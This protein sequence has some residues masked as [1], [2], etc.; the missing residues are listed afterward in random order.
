MRA[1][2]EQDHRQIGVFGA[3]LSTLTNDV[4]GGAVG[5]QILL[6]HYRKQ[7]TFEVGGR[8]DTDGSH[9]AAV[10]LGFLY[11]QAMGQHCVLILSSAVSKQEKIDPAVGVR[12]ELLIKF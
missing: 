10:G 1:G 5:Y 7:L 4:V 3:P 12:A 8:Q 11:Q 9:T 2:S 6:D